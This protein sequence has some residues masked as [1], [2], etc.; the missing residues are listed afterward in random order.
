MRAFNFRL[1]T[2][3]HLRE[4]SK[5]RA[6]ASYG[7]AVSIRKKANDQLLHAQ[8]ALDE[9][10]REI[11]LRRSVGFDG[12]SQGAFNRSLLAA[13]ERIIARNTDLQRACKLEEAKRSL[14]LEAER[15]FKSMSKLKEKRKE[16]HVLSESKKE[17]SELDDVIGA[18]FLTKRE[19]F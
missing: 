15:A 6:L 17:E 16:E 19:I 4:L 10:Q 14:F 8:E 7:E 3:L 13:K 2:L 11:A 5:D 18:R 9:L 12:S 1:E